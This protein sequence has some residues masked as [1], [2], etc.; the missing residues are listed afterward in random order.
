MKFSIQAM[1]LATL[2]LA[3]MLA[4]YKVVPTLALSVVL[5]V[6]LPAIGVVLLSRRG[7]ERW[8]L[9]ACAALPA[10]FTFYLGLIGPLTALLLMPAEW[11]VAYETLGIDFT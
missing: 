4:A 3:S 8:R 9:F 6:P 7:L 5:L 11:G 10:A 2:L 1:L